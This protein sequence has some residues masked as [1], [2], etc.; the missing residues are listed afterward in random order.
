MEVLLPVSSVILQEDSTFLEAN[1]VIPM[2]ILSLMP[3]MDALLVI[4]S[5]MD[6]LAVLPIMELQNV[7]HVIQIA[8]SS[9]LE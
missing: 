8:D 5:L 4:P 1:V 9:F 6:V 2:L 7:K 3:M